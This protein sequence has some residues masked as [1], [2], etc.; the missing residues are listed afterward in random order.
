MA[1]PTAQTAAQVIQDALLAI[2]IIREGQTPTADMQAQ[3][4]R[5]LNQMMALWEADGRNLGYIPVGT[6]TDVLTVPDA[7]ILGIY[8]TLAIMLAPGYGAAVSEELIAMARMGMDIIDKITAKEVSMDMDV[9]NPSEYSG[10]F[11]ISTG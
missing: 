4:I 2:K 3:A 10:S 5:R 8:A 1:T 9:P 6:V 11:N 7:A